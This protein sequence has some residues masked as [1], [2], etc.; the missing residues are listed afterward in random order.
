MKNSCKKANQREFQI[1]TIIKKGDKFYIKL[2]GCYNY[3]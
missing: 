1:E 2:K 3:V